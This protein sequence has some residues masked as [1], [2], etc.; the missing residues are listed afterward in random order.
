[1]F[2]KE[3]RGGSFRAGPLV[4]GIT[5]AKMTTL[6]FALVAVA[7]VVLTAIEELLC[8]ACEKRLMTWLA[9]APEIDAF[10]ELIFDYEAF[11]AVAVLLAGATLAFLST[12]FSVTTSSS[13]S[14][15][16][17]SMKLLW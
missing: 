3:G 15:S 13:P 8:G 2:V 5:L 7:I 16:S 9:V 4:S 12:A 1:M 17:S 11:V 6:L 10:E 14:F